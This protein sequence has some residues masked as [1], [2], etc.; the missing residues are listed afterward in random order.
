MGFIVSLGSFAYGGYLIVRKFVYDTA[1]SG[2]T[3]TMVVL[4]ILGGVQLLALGALGEYIG[5]IYVENQSRPLYVVARRL[6]PLNDDEDRG[7]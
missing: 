2:W 5:R 7:V 6:A 4:L 1:A 3:S